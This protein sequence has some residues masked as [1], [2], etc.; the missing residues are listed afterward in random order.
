MTMVCHPSLTGLFC[1]GLA[2]R[3]AVTTPIFKQ[4]LRSIGIVD[5]NRATARRVLEKPSV[6]GIS[7]GAYLGKCENGAH[8]QR[9]II[10]VDLLICFVDS[11]GGVAEIFE[12][13]N[14][15]EVILLRERK[16]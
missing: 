14:D 4:I 13:N 8:Q 10:N 6:L 15:D 5:A 16:V 2:A 1:R 11:S 7:T 3:A 12:T 9:N